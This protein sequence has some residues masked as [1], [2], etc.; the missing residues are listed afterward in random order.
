V[1]AHK[2]PGGI[3]DISNLFKDCV[4]L[5]E[6]PI[7]SK[8]VT[9]M[10][11]TFEGCTSLT[12]LH[13]IPGTVTNMKRTFKGCSSLT[14]APS[15]P[16]GVVNMDNAFED[17]AK[18]ILPP[19]IPDSVESKAGIFNGCQ[20]ISSKYNAAL[21]LLK[22]NTIVSLEEAETMFQMLSSFED[23]KERIKECR[24][25]IGKIR[26]EE[27][28][29]RLEEEAREQERIAVEEKRKAKNRKTAIIVGLVLMCVV[30]AA[31]SIVMIAK[32]VKN[33]STY[34]EAIATGNAGHYKAAIGLLNEIPDYKDSTYYATKYKYKEAMDYGKKGNYRQALTLLKSISDYKDC[35]KEI[36][37]YKT[38]YKKVEPA[39]ICKNYEKYYIAYGAF[40][41]LRDKAETLSS[42]KYA[43]ATQ[44][45]K[46]LELNEFADLMDVAY[47]SYDDFS[48][49]EN[50]G[51]DY[52]T[53]KQLRGYKDIG[54]AQALYKQ[55]L[56]YKDYMGTY[57]AYDDEYGDFECKIYTYFYNKDKL[58]QLNS[59]NILI[60][61]NCTL[62][63]DGDYKFIGASS[64]KD[65][66]VLN[67]IDKEDV[68]L[69]KITI[70]DP[71]TV[72]VEDDDGGSLVLVKE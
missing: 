34:E 54:F 63:V 50:G 8:N 48:S 21:E 70:E 46:L 60:L 22:E 14:S 11:C 28:K 20:E 26:D 55:L 45:K 29:E 43:S 47:Y 35:D 6:M 44:K 69:K 12:E 51:F 49:K 57:S 1:K 30:I 39:D 42:S 13:K 64:L 41:A 2:I 32:H 61:F 68:G 24:I 52:S 18:L 66:Y 3:M 9:N 31:I 58:K 72:T 56:E 36:S 33:N 17:C 65:P 25:R 15:V 4:N 62:D 38:L 5:I 37:K 19:E 7:I 23:S 27:E 67:M 71:N 10:N 16:K 59:S 40:S 53:L